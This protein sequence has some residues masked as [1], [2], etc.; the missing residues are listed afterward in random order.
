MRWLVHAFA[1]SVALLALVPPAAEARSRGARSATAGPGLVVDVSRL[2]ALGLGQTADLIQSAVARELAGGIPGA[3]GARIVVR[4]TGLSLNS[5]V[6]S[7][8]VGGGGAGGDSGSGGG[9]GEYDYLEGDLLVVG[10]R[11]EVLAQRH[12][13]VSSP[14]SAGG[15]YYLPGSEDRRVVTISR[16]FAEWLR[17]AAI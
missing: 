14:S 17:R 6:G 2:K 4:L 16:N 11:G 1:V 9:G 3:P 12:Q 5:Y 15:A 13:V 7:S 10:A 8:G